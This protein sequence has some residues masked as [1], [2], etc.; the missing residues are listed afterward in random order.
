MVKLRIKIKGNDL[1]AFETD[2]LKI[3]K[4]RV[5]RAMEKIDRFMFREAERLANL[6]RSSQEFREL[7]TPLLIGKF[8]FTPSELANLDAIF[9]LIAPGNTNNQITKVKKR[10]FSAHHK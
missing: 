7:K 5:V 4:A 3:I 6:V 2:A 9:P 10:L 8:G 1:R